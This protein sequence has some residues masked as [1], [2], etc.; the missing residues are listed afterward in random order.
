VLDL[1]TKTISSV[2]P[3]AFSV[4][5]IT[6][7]PD[8]ARLFVARTGRLGSDVAV[9]HL[10]S[11][12]ITSIPVAGR[13]ASSID[14]LR[15]GTSGQ[16]CASLSSYGEGELIVI[17]S[18][19]RQVVTTLR[20]GA[21]VRDIALSPDGTVGYVLAYH[22]RGAAALFCVDLLR[23]EIGAVVDVSESATQVVMSPGGSE[24]YVVR[25]DELRAGPALRR[26]SRGQ[27]DNPARRHTGAS[28]SQLTGPIRIKDP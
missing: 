9:I 23:R 4:R 7:S 24:V 25:R 6:V 22:P 21:P 26:R 11:D 1:D 5:G 14:A 28:G 20:V 2:H 17:D 8:G 12:E 16:L 15:V 18:A 3:L 19:R 13:G 27:C 10:A